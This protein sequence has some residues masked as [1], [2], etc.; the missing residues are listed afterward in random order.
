MATQLLEPDFVEEVQKVTAAIKEHS[1][2]HPGSTTSVLWGTGRQE[3]IKIMA[4]AKSFARKD[5]AE[6]VQDP[7]HLSRRFFLKLFADWVFVQDT[8]GQ[9]FVEIAEP[10]HPEKDFQG[11]V[12]RVHEKRERRVPYSTLEEVATAIVKF[13]KNFPG[14][15]ITQLHKQLQ[16]AVW[17]CPRVVCLLDRQQTALPPGQPNLQPPNRNKMIYVNPP[18]VN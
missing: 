15:G 10:V 1:R 4:R 5:L 16:T 11:N 9:V 12:V 3:C 6:A 14:Q 8:T 2:N 17:P 7:A 13:R 18:G